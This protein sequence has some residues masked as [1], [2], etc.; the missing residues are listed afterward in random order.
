MSLTL[1]MHPL[2]SFCHKALVALY[3]YGAPFTPRIVNLGDAADRAA[4]AAVWP[5]GQFP[6][7][8]DDTRGETVPESSVLI[9]YL[10]RLYAPAGKR[11]IP[12][13]ADLAHETRLWDR[14]FDLHV[15]APMQKV[16]GDRIRPKDQRDPFGVA[17][18]RARLRTAL[19]MIDARMATRTWA[20]G[21]RFTMADCAAAPALFYADKVAPPSDAHPNAAAYLRRLIE[22]PSYARALSEAAPYMHMFPSE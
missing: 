14:V 1:Y 9:E 4:F 3:E 16:T 13:D 15:Q 20:V 5:M 7:L 6:V 2:S 11:L 12:E 19:D 10:D 18:A 8:R 22:R 21:E 17:Q